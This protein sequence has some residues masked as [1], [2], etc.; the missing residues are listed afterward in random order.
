MVTTVVLA[1]GLAVGWVLSTGDSG[2]DDGRIALRCGHAGSRVLRDGLG[3][4]EG[5]T[6][7]MLVPAVVAR[8][9]WRSRRQPLDGFVIGVL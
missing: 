4:A 5:G 9:M 2:H 8:L 7:L 1:F 3:I 6:L